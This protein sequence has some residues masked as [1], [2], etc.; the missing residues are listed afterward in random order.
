MKDF[1]AAFYVVE[2]VAQASLL[3]RLL[4]VD[5]DFLMDA[6]SEYHTYD[7]YLKTVKTIDR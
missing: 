6:T 4:S 7:A 2:G 1:L 3:I 5:P